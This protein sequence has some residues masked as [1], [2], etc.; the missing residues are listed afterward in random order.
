MQAIGNTK[1]VT[2]FF[3]FLKLGLTSF[4]GPA[5]HIAYFR[6]TFVIQ[7]RWL[8]E[9]AFAQLFAI[10]HFLPG[11]ASSQ[12]GFAIGLLHGGWRGAIAAFIGFTLPS[13]LLLML[14]ISALPT[15]PASFANTLIHGLKIVALVVVAD[16]SIGM[17]RNFCQ[18]WLTRSIACLTLI[19][20]LTTAISMQQVVIIL[21]SGLLGAYFLRSH[22]NSPQ[23]NIQVSYTRRRGSILLTLFSLLLILA[24]TPIAGNAPSIIS[25][26]QWFYQIGALVFGGG[27]VVLPLIADV[28]VHQSTLTESELMAGYGAAQ[29]L[30]GPLFSVAAY[31]G[32]KLM[33]AESI[34]WLGAVAATTAIFLP[35]FLLMAGVLPFW[36]ALSQNK[37]IQGAV[38]GVNAAVV[39]LL[40]AT[41]YQPLFTSTM[42]TVTDWILASIGIVIVHQKRMGL[43]WVIVLIILVNMAA[44]YL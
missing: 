7:K 4:G 20:S 1:A 12:L 17:A 18:T 42:L 30:P 37:V 35:G 40:A 16:A 43:L 36:Q 8:S 5:A 15:L 23:T 31:Y 13:V 6:Q 27:H 34:H 9:D 41:W 19:I 3:A 44:H 10:G 29:G 32:S 38:V 39:G 25:I 11:P 2:I 33:S 28:V 21:G 22:R 24:L 26:S 14:F